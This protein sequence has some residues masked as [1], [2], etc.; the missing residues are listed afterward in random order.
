V[1]AA[2]TLAGVD[3]SDEL[4]VTCFI[5]GLKDAED[6]LFVLQKRPAN[7]KEAYRAVVTLR[8]RQA[9]AH[10]LCSAPTTWNKPKERQLQQ[11][12]RQSEDSLPHPRDPKAG[13]KGCPCCGATYHSIILCHNVPRHGKPGTLS[14]PSSPPSLLLPPQQPPDEAEPPL[15]P[16]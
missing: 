8:L 14:S 5:R 7:L 1:D 16:A 4:K 11:A 9:R 13:R 15:E 2:L 12:R 3:M 10:V 6:R